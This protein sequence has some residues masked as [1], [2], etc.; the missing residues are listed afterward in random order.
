MSYFVAE[1][2][3]IS[4]SKKIKTFRNIIL[5]VDLYGASNGASY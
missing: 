1:M 5:P 4:L 3:R 2:N